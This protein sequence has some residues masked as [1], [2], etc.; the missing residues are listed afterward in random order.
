MTAPAPPHG[1]TLAAPD[2]RGADLAD[3]VFDACTI[4]D[5]DFTDAYL[6]GARFTRCRLTRGAFTH[7][8][9]R[10]VVFEDCVLAD[11]STQNGAN[12]A[13]TRLDEARFRRCDLTHA[14]FESA[15]L[16]A[17]VFEDCNLL[18]A[19]FSRARFHRAFGRNIVRSAVGFI[20]CNLE[21]ADLSGASLGECDFSRSRLRET[22]I[23][24][25]NLEGA[26]LCDADLFR[27]IIDNARMTG[28]DLRGAEVSGFDLRRLASYHDLK[29]TAE[30]QYR[31]L[32][33]LGI[34]VHAAKP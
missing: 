31:L 17:A 21:L 6:S 12:F 13:F 32:D 5:G 28:A 30:Q 10:E 16:Y 3:H 1:V 14:R 15:D 27:A 8:D 22:D 9:A 29:I 18:G 23:S 33:A 4:G 34:D 20:A 19:R 25:C 24:G 11:R 26:T 2:W 7:A